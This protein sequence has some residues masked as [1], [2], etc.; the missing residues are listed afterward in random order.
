MNAGDAGAEVLRSGSSGLRG[1]VAMARPRLY[2]AEVLTARFF[3]FLARLA[4]R[5]GRAS[6]GMTS[7]LSLVLSS[8]EK[9][10]ESMA[11]FMDGDCGEAPGDGSVMDDE[12]SDTVV[13]GDESAESEADVD[14]LWRG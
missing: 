14:V 1:V 11:K 13:V 4:A 5:V 9:R 8:A 10:E 12:S 6:A 3:R 7:T 2:A